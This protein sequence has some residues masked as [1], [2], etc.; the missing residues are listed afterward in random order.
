[1]G[2]TLSRLLGPVATWHVLRVL[3]EA[4]AAA[5]RVDDS[6]A[7]ALVSVSRGQF[8]KSVGGALIAMTVLSGTK[9]FSP[10][11]AAAQDR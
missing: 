3:G 5:R 1:M 4:G 11:S 2:L 7:G 9:A 10:T 8:L 6:P